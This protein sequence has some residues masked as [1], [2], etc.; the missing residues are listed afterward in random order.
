MTRAREAR[1]P[2]GPRA[3]VTSI[4]ESFAGQRIERMHLH[5]AQIVGGDHANVV[6]QKADVER[7]LVRECRLTGLQAAGASLR[8]VRL[9]GCRIDLALL[10]EAR[11]ERVVVED[12]VLTDSSL[13]G[14]WLRDVRFEGCDLTAVVF[15][16]VRLVRVEFHGCR[17]AGVR[18]E[19][20]RGARMPWPDLVEHAGEL[21]AALGIE[22][23]H[24]RDG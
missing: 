12:C 20:L 10:A 18:L 15:T 17:L 16:G 22:V 24:R 1:K 21:A 7:V 3:P 2:F 4:A 5:D 14:A 19:H 9:S 13:E 6:T 11:V 8:D 23:C